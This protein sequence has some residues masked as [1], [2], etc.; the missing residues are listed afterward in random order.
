MNI[1]RINNVSLSYGVNK[2]LNNINIEINSSDKVGLVGKNGAGK[3]SLFRIINKEELQDTGEVITPKGIEI[4]TLSQEF[5]LSDESTV[6]DECLKIYDDVLNIE[7]KMREIEIRMSEEKDDN[8]LEKLLNSYSKITHEYEEKD[9]YKVQSEIKGVLNGLGFKEND[10]NRKVKT[11]SG[12][13]KSKLYLGMLLVEKPDILLLDE[14]TNHLDIESISWLESIL[15]NYEKTV[16]CI[17]HDRYFLDNVVDKIVEIENLSATLYHTNYSG[18]VIEKKKK[19]INEL[20]EFELNQKEIKR[21]EEIIRKL[22]VYGTSSGGSQKFISRARSRQ[23]LLD[24]MQVKEKPKAQNKKMKPRFKPSI[25]SGKDVL[26]VEN[27]SKTIGDKNLYNNINFEIHRD[28]TVFLLGKNGTGKTT[29]FNQILDMD[30]N[31]IKKGT[32]VLLDMYDQHLENLHQDNTIYDEIAYHNDGYDNNE[33]RTYL[34]SFLFFNED[35]EKKIKNLSGGEKS[36]LSLLKL[37]LTGA[38]ML[39]LDEPTN[40]LDIPSREALEEAIMEY[41]GTCFIISHDRYFINKLATKIIEIDNKSVNIYNGD[42]DYFLDIKEK[43]KLEKLKI[44]KENKEIKEKTRKIKNKKE[45]KVAINYEKKI[46]DLE[47]EK[48]KLENSLYDISNA[49]DYQKLSEINEELN[50][51]IIELEKLYELWDNE[52]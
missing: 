43:E 34:A 3:T 50:R 2:V 27:L 22:M 49:N 8:R 24:K 39:F 48:E 15:Q 52:S 25:K 36:R 40:H 28:Q 42:Y 18:Y 14:P 13:E 38:N 45:K 30:E 35:L 44:D 47:K 11:L 31:H 20:K 41:D 5:N 32:N 10:Y 9:G 26:R 29:L 4:G 33:I 16:I 7:K 46:E 17:S 51:I 19:Y 1:L 37:M 23:K 12:G 6:Y 21:Q